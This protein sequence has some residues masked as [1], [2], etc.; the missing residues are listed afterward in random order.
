[1]N[2]G[3]LIKV[4]I[5][6]GSTPVY[7]AIGDLVVFDSDNYCGS[8]TLPFDNFIKYSKG[9]PTDYIGYDGVNINLIF[10]DGSY[11]SSDGKQLNSTYLQP[12]YI[13]Q[14]EDES[15]TDPVYERS[16]FL[17]RFED[18][19][20]KTYVKTLNSP[21]NPVVVIYSLLIKYG[22]IKL[23]DFDNQSFF[24]CALISRDTKC[25]CQIIKED[26]LNSVLDEIC[27]NFNLI[28]YENKAGKV[29][30][31]SLRPP[32]AD[33][34]EEINL[35]MIDSILIGDDDISTKQTTNI[36]IDYM[37]NL[38]KVNDTEIVVNNP[39][40]DFSSVLKMEYNYVGDDKSAIINANIKK[41]F[42][43]KPSNLVTLYTNVFY[44]EFTW[45]KIIGDDE[46]IYFIYSSSIDLAVLGKST[47]CRLELFQFNW[48]EYINNMQEYSYSGEQ[49]IQE[50]IDGEEGINEFSE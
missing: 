6:G 14:I 17:I 23:T 38:I 2:R 16:Y 19:K 32:I 8:F 46:N 42:H 41:L 7:G 3:R 4:T 36:D 45:V 37:V 26:N 33:S 34:F 5:D 48:K 35:N 50:I 25:K 12:S 13:E 30:I 1:M 21:D 31:Q 10:A 27:M 11:Y 9:K 24:D 40:V 43:Y 20:M 29:A 39:L 18:G 49:N 44:D 15:S 28:L 22:G 47:R